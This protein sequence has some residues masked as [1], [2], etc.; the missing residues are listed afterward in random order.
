MKIIIEVSDKIIDEVSEKYGWKKESVVDG[1]KDWMSYY[2][3]DEFF[4]EKLVND[5]M[6]L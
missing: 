5:I 3:D 2:E 1:I 4:K 6:S